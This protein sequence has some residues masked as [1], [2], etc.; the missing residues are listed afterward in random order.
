MTGTYTKDTSRDTKNTKKNTAEHHTEH[1]RRVI[2]TIP[3]RRRSV[4]NDN[5]F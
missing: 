2:T 3:I 1:T 5:P 4:T